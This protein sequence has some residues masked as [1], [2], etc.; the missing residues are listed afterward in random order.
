MAQNSI[1]IYGEVISN[2]SF[3]HKAGDIDFYKFEMEIRRPEEPDQDIVTIMIPGSYL[4]DPLYYF[5]IGDML[6]VH[7]E[8]RS[9]VNI[10]TKECNKYIYVHHLRINENSYRGGRETEIRLEA[11][12]SKLRFEKNHV[13][14]NLTVRKED[15]RQAREYNMLPILKFGC[16]LF[17]CFFV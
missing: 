7:G 15:K 16:L 13:E 5:Q 1:I 17:G 10:K 9:Y 3:S 14:A 6:K 11:I 8:L 12:I 2:P 4:E